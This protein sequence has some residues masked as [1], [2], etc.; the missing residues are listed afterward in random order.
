M[1][2]IYFLLVSLAMANHETYT[3][4]SK[5][6]QN[7]TFGDTTY[8]TMPGRIYHPIDIRDGNEMGY[9][10]FEY[11]EKSEFRVHGDAYVEE[12]FYVGANI[13]LSIWNETCCA[14]LY[15]PNGEPWKFN[16]TQY[17]EET[18]PECNATNVTCSGCRQ[19]ILL[20]EYI[21]ETVRKMDL[22]YKV[23]FSATYEEVTAY[24]YAQ[25]EG[26]EL[27]GASPMLMKLKITRDVQFDGLVDIGEEEST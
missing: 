12:S 8:V 7:Y 3:D 9:G 27:N 26:A 15:L 11:P 22:L 6:V 5:P 19:E 14:P 1:I 2:L 17:T 4:Q 16:N 23:L 18:C 13:T 21:E 20:S 10:N 25:T 24:D